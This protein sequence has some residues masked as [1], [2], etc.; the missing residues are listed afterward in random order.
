[1]HRL[2]EQDKR[3][4]VDIKQ[5][6][7]CLPEAR[8]HSKGKD[9]Q[10]SDEKRLRCREPEIACAFGGKAGLDIYEEQR[11]KPEKDCKKECS[12]FS[13][14]FGKSCHDKSLLRSLAMQN[15]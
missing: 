13:D 2:P 11:V 6:A 7:E 9:N 8:T 3:K 15:R 4:S 12:Y 10:K 14:G 5:T 1:M